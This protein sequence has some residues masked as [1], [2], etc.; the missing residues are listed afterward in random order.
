MKTSVP[1]DTALLATLTN[2]ASAYRLFSRLFLRP[3]SGDEV[4]A[5]AGMNLERE[6]EALGAGSL[7][8]EGFNDMGRG[9]H[10]RHSGTQRLLSTDYTMCF[11][12]VSS[13][14]G[15]VAVPYAS[16]FGGSITG[17]KAVLF[18]EPRDRDLAAYRREGIAADSG[19]HLPE[20][21]ISFELSFMADLSDKA[22]DAVEAKDFAEAL[23]LMDASGDFLENHILSWYGSF[24]DL[25]T[26]IIDTRFYRGVLKATYGYLEADETTIGELRAALS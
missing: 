17:E 4:E 22:R 26:K 12:G 8:A 14:Q 20:D 2:R 5:L 21:H 3:L 13:F 1:T 7:L 15:L 11:D 16:V 24:Y 10:R 9:L 23:R 6:S 18:Q 25:A 19:L